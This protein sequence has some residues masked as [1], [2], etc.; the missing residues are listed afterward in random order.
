MWGNKRERQDNDAD[1]KLTAAQ[2]QIAAL[3]GALAER[4]QRLAG[5][6]SDAAELRETAE[7]RSAALLD[8]VARYRE[9]RLLNAP[10]IPEDLVPPSATLAE[11]DLY[12]ERAEKVVGKVQERLTQQQRDHGPG[13]PATSGSAPRRYPDYSSLSA[14]EKIR[15]GLQQLNERETAKR[16]LDGQR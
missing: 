8:A 14:S 13:L 3:H 4:D 6:E 12:F 16:N 11:V 10:D 7:A 1:Q 15:I 9:V 2:E 5:L